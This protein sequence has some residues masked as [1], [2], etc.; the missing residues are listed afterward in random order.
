MTTYELWF[1]FAECGGDV[2]REDGG[3]G[4]L[5]ISDEGQFQAL[6]RLGGDAGRR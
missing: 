6:P 1:L 2:L 5:L 3:G 4:A